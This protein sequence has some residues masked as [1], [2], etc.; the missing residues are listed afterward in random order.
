MTTI[1]E[2]AVEKIVL[3]V[4]VEMLEELRKAADASDMPVKDYIL[5]LIDQDIKRRK[6]GIAP[7]KIAEMLKE[8]SDLSDAIREAQRRFD[9]LTREHAEATVNMI[10]AKLENELQKATEIQTQVL[11]RIMEEKNRIL[12]EIRSLIETDKSPDD[13]S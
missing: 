4:P 1:E 6:P 12:S 5:R 2:E 10:N 11:P 9:L 13:P 7:E 8:D 3:R